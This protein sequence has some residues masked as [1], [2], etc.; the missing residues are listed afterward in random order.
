[1]PAFGIEQ[2]RREVFLMLAGCATAMF[3]PASVFQRPKTPPSVISYRFS[4]RQSPL[5]K[6]RTAFAPVFAISPITHEPVGSFEI[7]NISLTPRTITRSPA[8]E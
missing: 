7:E 2:G 5:G 3:R 1:M 8:A 6:I 4:L